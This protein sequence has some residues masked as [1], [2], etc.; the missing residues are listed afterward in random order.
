MTLPA[1]PDDPFEPF[2]FDLFDAAAEPEPERP[3]PLAPHQIS[4]A[5][6]RAC[7][8]ARPA[9]ST[10]PA[11]RTQPHNETNP[12]LGF[13]LFSPLLIAP[14]AAVGA[15]IAVPITTAVGL[16]LGGSGY[17]LAIGAIVA[18]VVL[19]NMN[20]FKRSWQRRL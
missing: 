12:L 10:R 5:Q 11:P 1:K 6:R 8:P 14:L 4:S 9:N 17:A 2:D 16:I 7:K 18:V 3:L 13:V 19:A 20:M 15:A